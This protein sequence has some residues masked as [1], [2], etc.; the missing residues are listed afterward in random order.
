M[1]ANGSMLQRLGVVCFWIGVAVAAY[2]VGFV[3]FGFAFRKLWAAKAAFLSAPG[4][5]TAVGLGCWIRYRF[6]WRP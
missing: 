2:L 4:A 1:N 6:G 5:L 3:A